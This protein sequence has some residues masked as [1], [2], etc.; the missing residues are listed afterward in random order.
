MADDGRLGDL[1]LEVEVQGP[2]LDHPEQQRRDVAGVER[3]RAGRHRGRQVVRRDDRHAVGR[4]DR[5]AGLRQLDVAAQRR[6]RHVDDDRAR[7]HL[8]DGLGRD[9]ERRLAARDLGG[10]D[11]DVHAADDLVELGLLGGSLLGRQLAGVA[12]GAG[13]VDGRLEL[14]E[15]GAQAL[16]LLA[17]LG[18]DVVGLDHR[19]EA[20]G[21]ADRLEPGHA[22]AQDQDVGRLGRPGRGRQEREVAAVG[23]GRDEHGLVAADVGLRR[24]RVHRLRAR[25]RA[26]DRVEADRGHAAVGQRLGGLRIDE[27]ARAGRARPGPAR[28]L[29]TSAVGRLGDAQDRVGVAV[30]VVGR[31]DR[32]AGLFVRRVGDRRAGAGAALDEDVE[33]GRLELAEHFGY[34]GDAP[35]SGRGLLGDTDLHGHHL[36]LEFGRGPR[37][38]YVRGGHVGSPARIALRRPDRVERRVAVQVR[39][40]A[41]RSRRGGRGGGRG[42]AQRPRRL[43]ARRRCAGIIG[44]VSSPPRTYEDLR[45]SFR[46]GVPERYNIAVDAIDR[47]AAA[48]PDAPALIAEDETGAVSRLDLRGR[49]AGVE[50][51]GQRPGGARARPRRPGRDPPAPGAGDGHRPRGGLPRR[52]HRGPAVRAVRPGGHRVPAGRLGRRRADH[53]RG[54]LAQ[55]RRGPRPSARPADDRRGRRRRGRRD[56]RLRRALGAASAAFRPSTPLADDPAIIIYTS[57]TTGPPKGALHAHRFLLGHMPGVLLPQSFPPQ[58]GDIFWTPA[59][60]AWIG[61]LYDVLFPAWHWGLPVLA[62]RARKFDPER[63]LDL[64]AR[65]AVRNV[66]LPPTAL[67]LIRRVRRPAR[68]GPAPAVRGQRRRDARRRAAGLGPRTFGVDDQR[69]LRPDRVQPRRLQQRGIM[70]SPAGLDGPRRCPGHEVAIID[71]DGSV[72]P[73]AT[74]ARSPSR[75]PTRSCSSATG[76]GPRRRAPSSAAT[77]C[78]PATGAGMDDDGYVWYQARNDDVITSGGYRIGPGEIE[79]CLLRHPAVA[80]VAVV[81][82]PDADRTE[83]VKAFVVLAPGTVPID[84]ADGRAP[85]VRPRAPGGPRV[86]ARDRL[87]RRA[88]ADGDRQGHAAGAA[89]PRLIAGRS[90]GWIL[91]MNIAA[92]PSAASTARTSPSCGIAPS[93]RR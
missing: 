38:G 36:D 42:A 69:V 93:Q 5:L 74:S 2:V 73:P 46:W 83:I 60:W 4:L 79:D 53:R 59:D 3:G 67:K 78:G 43:P 71:D 35:F 66:F 13:R 19:A 27:R 61:G 11:D 17:R 14:D 20:A 30:Q 33:P 45:R 7:L 55:G 44:R 70:P 81:G 52:A 87:P 84:R 10:R 65:H 85:G 1:V 86:P 31:D 91:M 82:I 40:A 32:R 62:H 28:S 92:P 49:P 56:A 64:M 8:P 37:T 26:R 29:P 48:R 80:M 76:T 41:P 47:H 63:A 50:P 16:G 9:Q 12:A 23:V 22:D 75:G 18:P 25:Q 39:V 89:R 58:P 57:G 54:E 90:S 77:G 88:A 6:G 68:A 24:Q 15:L 72:V 34:Q 21:G 51:A